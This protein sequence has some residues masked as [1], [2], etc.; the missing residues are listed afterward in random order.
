MSDI[1]EVKRISEKKGRGVI[2]KKKIKKGSIID[3]AHTILIPNDHYD[4]IQNTVLYDYIFEW[5]DP[6]YEGEYKCVIAL[7]VSQFINHSYTPNVRYEY[8]YTNQTIKFIA[9]K[10]IMEG[11]ELLVNYNGNVRDKSPMWFDVE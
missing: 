8:D 11:E 5:D 3:V 1:I 2:S 6:K 10:D 7:S 4:L 9:I